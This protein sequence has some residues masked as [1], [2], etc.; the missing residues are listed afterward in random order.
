[1]LKLI[2]KVSI[3]IGIQ[4]FISGLYMWMNLPIPDSYRI[5]CLFPL[6]FV[7]ICGG[8]LVLFT[9]GGRKLEAPSEPMDTSYRDFLKS[10]LKAKEQVH[11]LVTDVCRFSVLFRCITLDSKEKLDLFDLM[12]DELVEFM[13][14]VVKLYNDRVVSKKLKVAM[15]ELLLNIRLCITKQVVASRLKVKSDALDMNLAAAEKSQI[16]SIVLAEK[17]LDLEKEVHRSL[18]ALVE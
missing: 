7:T 12:V 9:Y 2:D 6:F 3:G 1:M 13:D 17:A 16:E 11:K 15:H 14:Q 18:I 8:A 5:Y 4:L 10:L